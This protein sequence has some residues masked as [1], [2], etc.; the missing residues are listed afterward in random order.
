[1]SIEEILSPLPYFGKIFYM[2][3]LLWIETKQADL[4]DSKIDSSNK[5]K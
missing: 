2:C 1:M 4:K 3:A 5:N